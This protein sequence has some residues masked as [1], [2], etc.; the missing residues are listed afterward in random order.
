MIC[1][2]YVLV[3]L[4]GSLPRLRYDQFIQF[5]WKI[6]ISASL[7]WILVVASLRLIS[8][9]GAPRPVLFGFAGVVVVLVTALTTALDSSQPKNLTLIHTD[10]AAPNFACPSL[11]HEISSI[12]VSH[13]GGDRD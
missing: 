13:T 6:L 7:L 2:F 9:E 8:N 3:W 5:G 10:S 11:T 12:N 1:F 4:R